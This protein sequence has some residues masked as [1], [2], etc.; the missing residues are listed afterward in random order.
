MRARR[1]G[2]RLV[3]QVLAANV[4]H[5][6][7]HPSP[8]RLPVGAER[9]GHAGDGDRGLEQEP[10]LQPQRGLVVQQVLPPVRDH[11]LGNHDRDH[12][13]GILPPQLAHISHDGA[14]GL[15]VRR[16]DHHQRDRDAALLPLA[17]QRVVGAVGGDVHRA[18]GGRAASP[19]RRP[20]PAASGPAGS[21]RGPPCGCARAA[22]PRRRRARAA[23][24]SRGSGAR[25]PSS[26]R[27]RI[28]AA[29]TTIQA[30]WLNLVTRTITKTS[31]VAIAPSAV[32]DALALQPSALPGR[33]RSRAAATNAG[34]C[35]PGSA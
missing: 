14:D 4:G 20:A 28:G 26:P 22:R 19:G 18:Q 9:P 15:A 11:V 17:R 34:P 27:K 25:R 5:R 33:G 1:F 3:E 2:R 7:G 21:R 13:P 16:L 29:M 6:L 24:R 8:A 12:V 31:A 23:R 32:D 35:P 10:A 30:P